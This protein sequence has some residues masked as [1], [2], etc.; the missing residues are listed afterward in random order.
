M[1][2]IPYHSILWSLQCSP[3][4][5]QITLIRCSIQSITYIPYA[6]VSVKELCESSSP[7]SSLVSLQRLFLN[8]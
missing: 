1:T 4:K 7:L 6:G 8:L 2:V 5:N 3:V